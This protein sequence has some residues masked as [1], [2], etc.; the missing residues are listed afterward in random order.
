M[1]LGKGGR[2]VSLC[3]LGSL[4][5]LLIELLC[6]ETRH[7]AGE[8]ASRAGGG[9]SPSDLQHVWQGAQAT[10]HNC[11]TKGARSVLSPK[12]PLNT[13]HMATAFPSDTAW[14]PKKLLTFL[15]Q[16]KVSAT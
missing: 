15:Q 6:L 13:T 14:R 1:G 12:L 11:S 7:A 5:S 9:Q 4:T 16:F 10:E 2:A 8:E 3:E